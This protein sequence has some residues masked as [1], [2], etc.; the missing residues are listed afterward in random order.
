MLIGLE[1]QFLVILIVA[2]LHK[3]YFTVFMKEFFENV[4]FE[5]KSVDN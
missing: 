4:D 5:N 1:N 3:F 2:V